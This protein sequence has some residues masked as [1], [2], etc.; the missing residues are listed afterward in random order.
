MENRPDNIYPL[1]KE[2][3]LE[4]FPHVFN[5]QFQTRKIAD[6]FVW[7]ISINKRHYGFMVDTYT[8][9]ESTSAILI[10]KNNEKDYVE[11]WKQYKRGRVE[12]CYSFKKRELFKEI[13][14]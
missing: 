1:T 5:N 10:D 9:G 6:D 2:E 4:H 12:Y 3:I 8:K 11:F 13:L 14:N 7:N